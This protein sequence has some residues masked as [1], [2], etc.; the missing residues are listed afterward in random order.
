MTRAINIAQ[1][2][3]NNFTMRN[4]IINGDMRIDQRNAG[5][6]VTA[7]QSVYFVDR[8]VT[9]ATQTSK[10]TAQ[11]STTAPAG[12]GNSFVYTSSSAYSVLSTDYF[13][14]TQQIE[15]N[16]MID[17]AWGTSSAATVTLSFWVRSSLTGTF[18]GSLRNNAG[19]RSYPFTYTIT[20]ANT[21]E[22]KSITIAGDTSGSWPL[23]NGIGIRV[24]FGMGVGSNHLGTAGS[25]TSA[26]YLGAIGQS[27][28]VGTNGA[29]F[30]ITG[31]QLE[32]G[33]TATPFENRPYGME[34]ALC[35]RYFEILGD[36][37]ASQS[38]FFD[39]YVNAGGI[40][41][42]I[43]YSFAAQKRALPTITQVGSFTTSNCGAPTS[44]AG[45][46]NATLWYASSAAGRVY[47]YNTG[48]YYTASAEL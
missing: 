7:N 24:L 18:G 25:W 11:Q 41:L 44:S 2:G 48:G 13:G 47:W 42:A 30:Y 3:G 23:T 45:K 35:Q 19:D 4:R 22:Q 12:F 34:L 17:F 16:N 40:N 39:A 10:A 9:L 28:V 37:G 15:G 31:V 32:A 36:S 20:A 14:F 46:G 38:L 33:S 43:P 29:T 6:A 1:S 5:A 27:S 21:W 8:W 26:N